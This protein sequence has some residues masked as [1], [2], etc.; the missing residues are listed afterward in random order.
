MIP[1]DIEKITE[2]DLQT[3]I[4][5][6]VMEGKTIE[7]KLALP[8]NSDSE[9]KEFL[10]D[11]SS[12]ANATGG[13]LI[14]GILSDNSTGFPK[15]LDGVA[16]QNIDQEVSRIDNILRDGI[17]PRI[18]TCHIQ[19]VRLSNGTFAI[20]IRIPKSWLSPHRVSY[21]THDRFYSRS[22][23]GKYS[24]DVSELRIA[25]N[26]SEAT[27]E[28]IRRFRESRISKVLSEETP[29]PMGSSAKIIMHL[30][31]YASFSPAHAFDFS[32]ITSW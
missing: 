7:Y 23:N 16:C 8:G 9:K 30:V 25:F 3:L 19:P 29:V 1:K 31:P 17:E 13:D 27:T 20:I 21:K 28:R 5:N 14:Y 26:L 6:S 32:R 2:A 4:D 11:V 22:S 18:S 15:S 24:L 10:A 12:F